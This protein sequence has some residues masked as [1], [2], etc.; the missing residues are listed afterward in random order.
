MNF[1]EIYNKKIYIFLL[2]CLL[3]NLLNNHSIYYSIDDLLK[4]LYQ[5]MKN[6]HKNTYY[7]IKFISLFYFI[8]QYNMIYIILK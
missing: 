3:N 1:I 7:Y 5:S 2:N 6:N 8:N 4:K